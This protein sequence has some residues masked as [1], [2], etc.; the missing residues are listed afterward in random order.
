M[1]LEVFRYPVPFCIIRNF[2][3][4]EKYDKVKIELNSVKPYLKGTEYT[5]AS[6]LP[7]QQ[8]A[9]KRKGLFLNEHTHLHGNS[10]IN[11][12]FDTV[13]DPVNLEQLMNSSWIFG[14]LENLPKAGTLISLYEEGDE[15][16]YHRD[17]AVLSIIYYLFDGEFTGGDFFLQHVKVPI[18]NN[19]LI[20]FPSCVHHCVKPIV[21]PGKRWSITTFFNFKT[22]DPIPPEITKFK[23]FLS[24][25]EWNK[26]QE[27]IN[28][29]DWK[30]TSATPDTCKVMSMDL[31]KNE[32]FTDVLFKKIPQGP[33]ELDSVHAYGQTTGLN[34]EFFKE[35][36]PSNHTFILNATDIPL[37]F[38]NSWGGQT[39]FETESGRISEAPEPNLAMLF[40]SNLS[41]RYLAPSR[42]V[43]SMKVMIEWKLKKK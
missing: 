9:V 8:Y 19:S 41:R 42:Y 34:G 16:K 7:N 40:K 32:Y 14:Y 10:G 3:P 22:D 17:K 29:G 5:G 21:G 35:K 25:D 4:S 43:N 27:T 37:N 38:I 15:Y 6:K 39:E 26:V 31:S 12:I 1:D 13:V 11:S 20:I 33:W 23:N 18:E 28:T 24:P 2:L 36:R 30:I